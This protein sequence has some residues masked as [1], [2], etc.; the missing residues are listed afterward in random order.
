MGL[1]TPFPGVPWWEQ[2]VRTLLNWYDQHRRELPWREPPIDPY[3]VWISEIMLQQT[4]VETV[5]PYYLRFLQR[6]PNLPAL[7]AAPL[8]EVLSA[9]EGLGYYARARH[10]HVC[11]QQLT[12]AGLQLPTE[13]TRLRELPGI[14]DYTAAAIASIAGGE[15]RPAID[16]NLR[17]ALSR[18][19][20]WQESVLSP[21]QLGKA[22]AQQLAPVWPRQRPGDLNQ[23]IMDL[24]ATICL[25]RQPHCERCPVA[26]LCQAHQQESSPWPRPARSHRSAAE[27]PRLRLAVLLIVEGV[28]E[29]RTP[30]VGVSPSE[31]SLPETGWEAAEAAA[32]TSWVREPRV[33][34]RRRTDQGLFGGLWEFPTIPYRDPTPLRPPRRECLGGPLARRGWQELPVR[35]QV[36]SHRLLE[37]HPYLTLRPPHHATKG[38]SRPARPGLAWVPLSKLARLPMARSMRLLARALPSLLLP[39]EHT[40]P[41]ALSNWPRPAYPN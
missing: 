11:A 22:L 12:A 24:A 16:G 3:R 21:A 8:D 28:E 20:G 23:A 10:L 39:G 15:P 5:I 14:G 6:F 31:P 13:Y 19:L 36:L 7:A 32:T 26:H 38:E 17:R 27:L 37:L 34:C 1:T 40:L 35:Q 4:R 9:W 29:G 18:L 41:Q 2:V 25:P 33:L 30:Q